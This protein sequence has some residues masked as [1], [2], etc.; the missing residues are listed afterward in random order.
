MLLLL[1]KQLLQGL[2]SLVTP[3]IESL[4]DR[5]WHNIKGKYVGSPRVGYYLMPKFVPSSHFHENMRP[6]QMSRSVFAHTMMDQYRFLAKW[7]NWNTFRGNFA[8]KLRGKA[9]NCLQLPYWMTLQQ[10]WIEIQRTSHSH[11]YHNYCSHCHN[12]NTYLIVLLV[13]GLAE[14][15]VTFFLVGVAAAV[16]ARILILGRLVGGWELDDS[17]AE[18]ILSERVSSITCS[19]MSSSSSS[20]ASS[21]PSEIK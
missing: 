17:P 10:L 20:C 2:K 13:W 14:L 16:L 12:D 15:N 21:S 19:S 11:V 3:K 6:S 5:Y 9:C 1:S 18:L 8:K 4:E 7:L